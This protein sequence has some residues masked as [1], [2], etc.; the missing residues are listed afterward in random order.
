M[1]AWFQ[2]LLASCSIY[3]IFYLQICIVFQY[4]NIIVLLGYVNVLESQHIDLTRHTLL[5]ASTFHFIMIW[6]VK[7]ISCYYLLQ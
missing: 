5:N 1:G 7:Y 6:F 2:L 3:N 4:L